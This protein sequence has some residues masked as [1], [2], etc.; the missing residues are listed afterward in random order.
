MQIHNQIV[1]E[2]SNQYNVV[3]ITSHSVSKCLMTL[4]TK[5]GSLEIMAALAAS[6]A[7][8]SNSR[9]P[10]SKLV[11]VS[12][13]LLPQLLKSL[14]LRQQEGQEIKSQ[15]KATSVTYSAHSSGLILSTGMLRLKMSLL[16]QI[17]QWITL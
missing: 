14:P 6:R 3:A 12:L 16:D 9:I 7:T 1:H 2:Y 13:T 4:A 11:H 8:N 17:H 10:S 15:A 5:E